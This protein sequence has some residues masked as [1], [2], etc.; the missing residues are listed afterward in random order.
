MMARTTVALLLFAACRTTQPAGET[1]A[2]VVHPTGETRAAVVQ[3]VAQALSHAPVPVDDDALSTT[4]VV[5]VERAQLEANQRAIQGEDPHA[6]GRTEQF[7][8]VI[9]GERCFL[10]H[11]RTYRYYELPGTTCAPR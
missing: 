5:V 1:R 10:V 6:P 2:Y 7:H 8:V 9:R 4:G 3:A 11:E